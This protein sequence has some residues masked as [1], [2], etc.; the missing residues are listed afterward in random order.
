MSDI[1]GHTSLKE[2]AF[3]DQNTLSWKMSKDILASDSKKFLKTLPKMGMMQDGVLFELVKSAPHT[4]E[5]ESSLLPTLL[6]RDYKGVD[7][8]KE[9]LEAKLL[10]TPVASDKNDRKAS[11]N[12][13]GND[14]VSTVKLLPTPTAMHV[15]NHDE[16]IQAYEQ[17]IMDYKEGKTKGKPGASTGL[18]VRWKE[19]QYRL[20]WIK[21]N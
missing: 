17:R 12:W 4:R 18:A 2:L 9:G 10:P 1:Y 11:P 16:P 21:V 15:R 20:H 14:L 3:Y 7:G 8:R 13:K 19:K 5:Q 6:A